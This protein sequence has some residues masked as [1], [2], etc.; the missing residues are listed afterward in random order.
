MMFP[1]WPDL[2][3]SWQRA[4]TPTDLELSQIGGFVRELFVTFLYPY[5]QQSGAMP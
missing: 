5:F 2:G 1:A 3:Q 4:F